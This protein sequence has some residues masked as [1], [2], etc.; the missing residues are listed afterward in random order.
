M[1]KGHFY[2]CHCA[3]RTVLASTRIEY[4]LH[5]LPAGKRV[6]DRRALSVQQE[7]RVELS[8]VDS[9]VCGQIKIVATRK[10]M[11]RALVSFFD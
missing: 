5:W 7:S 11:V 10:G 4:L 8:R 6:K 9:S 2:A 1:S 3:T